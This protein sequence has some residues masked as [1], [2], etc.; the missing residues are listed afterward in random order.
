[1][2]KLFML[3]K[4]QISISNTREEMGKYGRGIASK[5][6]QKIIKE[7]GSAN[8]IF[9]SSPSQMDVLNELIGDKEI[10]W[11]K[12]NAF[13]M[14]EYIGI[15]PDSKQSFAQYLKSGLFSKVNIGNVF[16]MNGL[17]NDPLKECERYEKLLKEYPTDITFL[18]IGENGHIAFNDP[19]IADFNDP[20]YVKINPKLD[21]ECIAQQVTDGWFETTKDVPQSAIT[22]TI[23][24]LISAQYIFTSVP[25]STKANIIKIF[26]ESNISEVC[27][28][29]II[30]KCENSYLFLDKDSAKLLEKSL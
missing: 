10:D 24:A 16:Y 7:K 23:P 28:S 8:I 15:S 30:R 21:E 29:T 27:P 18:G 19:Y 9:A 4:L 13:H 12:I 25:A 20:K 26:Y 1:M 3:D 5:A 6:I 17:A 22:I 14:D 11:S 2:T